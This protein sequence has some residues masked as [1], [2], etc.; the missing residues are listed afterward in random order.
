MKCIPSKTIQAMDYRKLVKTFEREVNEYGGKRFDALGGI[1]PMY[2]Q[3]RINMLRNE[4]FNRL[5]L[6]TI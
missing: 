2:N 6:V 1:E 4:L 3:N 5:K